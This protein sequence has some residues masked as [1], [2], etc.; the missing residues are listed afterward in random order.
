M[1]YE[2]FIKKNN[3]RIAEELCYIGPS[4]A[5]HTR[6]E[7]L[8]KYRE[9]VARAEKGDRKASIQLE[10]FDWLDHDLMAIYDL[11]TEAPKE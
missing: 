6:D 7:I 4:G 1:D 10:L 3:A 5:Y 8:A 9:L 2:E 11:N